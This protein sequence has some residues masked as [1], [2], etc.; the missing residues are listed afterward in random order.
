MLIKPLIISVFIGLICFGL[1]YWW[2]GI[3]KRR[4]AEVQTGIANLASM[5]WRECVGLLIQS[6]EKEGYREEISSRQ[7]G[8][9][10]TEFLLK[11]GSA[12]TLLSYKHGTAY[13]LG[14]ANIRDF[15]NGVQLIGASKGILVTLGTI[16]QMGHD[17]AHRYGIDLI[18]GTGLWPR[19]EHFMPKQTLEAVQ[20]EA[21]GQTKSKVQ[22]GAAISVAVAALSFFLV[23]AISPS[24]PAPQQEVAVS[25]D[26]LPQE[27]AALPESAAAAVA[28][29]APAA[30]KVKAASPSAKPVDTVQAKIDATAKAFAEIDN[31]T[32][33][34]LA[35]RKADAAKKVL[36]LPQVRSA[37]WYS[38]T[39]LQLYLN[40]ENNDDKKLI[41]EICRI[42]IA[43]EELRYTRLQLEPP[44]GSSVPVR[45]RQCQ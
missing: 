26:E 37:A 11:K 16:D 12:L 8:D 39:T 14:E 10:G 41:D 19:V 3:V 23:W 5:R 25:Q 43:N 21:S 22:M 9:G 18:D 29:Q 27:A 24:S 4:Q 34:Q 13:H 33:E 1:C 45:F 2:I 15:A 40:T 32:T 28:V 7:P 38:G 6:L 31:L 17:L 30:N 42:V 44:S 20:R 35:A 36:G